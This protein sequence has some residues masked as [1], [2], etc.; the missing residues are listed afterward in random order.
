MTR[1]V[2]VI[3]H[4]TLEEVTREWE[5]VLHGPSPIEAY[6]TFTTRDSRKRRL[7]LERVDAGPGHAGHRWELVHAAPE[8]ADL[9]E[10]L[11]ARRTRNDLQGSATLEAALVEATRYLHEHPAG[12]DTAPAPTYP[13]T[14][15]YTCTQWVPVLREEV[16]VAW[17]RTQGTWEAEVDGRA[18]T[19]HVDR[20]D[21][22]SGR[23]V[24]AYGTGPDGRAEYEAGPHEEAHQVLTHLAWEIAIRDRVEAHHRAAPNTRPAPALRP[25][26]VPLRA[27][28][29]RRGV[30]APGNADTAEHR[31][32]QAALND[33]AEYLNSTVG[34]GHWAAFKS[35]TG[36]GG[37]VEEYVAD[38]LRGQ[39][40]VDV[41]VVA[42]DFR[43]ALNKTL[44]EGVS[45]QNNEFY[46]PSSERPPWNA[47]VLRAAID[48]VDFW[49]IV[50]EHDNS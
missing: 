14:E 22:R 8:D 40:D 46:G 21:S 29:H 11:A 10:K 34:Y 37:S 5:P 27:A 28:S 23:R 39:V 41:E 1:T 35:V 9:D 13:D 45:L 44:P 49:G 17:T 42:A 3:A 32:L 20:T 19:A 16:T 2:T 48:A 12:P 31:R 6:Q 7:V 50:A 24:W 15:T 36:W 26:G 47:D 18:W 43:A 30:D 25:R 38:A 4:R 33:R